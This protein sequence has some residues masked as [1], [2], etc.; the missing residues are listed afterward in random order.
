MTFHGQPMIVGVEGGLH[1]DFIG[2]LYGDWQWSEKPNSD[3][4]D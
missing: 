4:Q 3:N 1:Q 2:R